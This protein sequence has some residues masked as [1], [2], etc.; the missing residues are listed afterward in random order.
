[1]HNWYVQCYTFAW[2]TISPLC[3]PT[4]SLERSISAT[5]LMY[6]L[7]PVYGL[8]SF[9]EWV[10]NVLMEFHGYCY[11]CICWDVWKRVVMGC[12]SSYT[13]A[14]PT[15][16]YARYSRFHIFTL[17]EYNNYVFSIPYYFDVFSP[18]KW[19]TLEHTRIKLPFAKLPRGL[20]R[21]F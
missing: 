14:S 15:D 16:L 11:Q 2:T 3:E 1:M 19:K 5:P 18:P 8:D 6:V 12:S 21:S 17:L 9:F 7:F 20:V 4:T 13:L 10:V